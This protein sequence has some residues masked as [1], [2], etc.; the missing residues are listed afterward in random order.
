MSIPSDAPPLSEMKLRRSG[1]RRGGQRA[2]PRVAAEI[3]MAPSESDKPPPAFPQ[4]VGG[5]LLLS[6]LGPAPTKGPP[7]VPRSDQGLFR[8]R[9]GGHRQLKRVP[10]GQRVGVGVSE[11]AIGNRRP[12]TRACQKIAFSIPGAGIRCLSTR[13]H[14]GPDRQTSQS[15]AAPRG[16]W[17]WVSCLRSPQGEELTASSGPVRPFGLLACLP[18]LPPKAK[19]S[20][21]LPFLFASL[22]PCPA[23]SHF[24]KGWRA[25]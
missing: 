9:P 5:A 25:G 11:S 23:L 3:P 22:G 14:P 24:R 16:A 20:T 21:A 10:H 6:S 7:A 17:R 1:R 18:P 19:R 15:A 8:P 4:S 2:R 12:R 13:A